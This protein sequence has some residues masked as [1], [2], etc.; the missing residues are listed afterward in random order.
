MNIIVLGNGFNLAHG[1]PTHYTDF[2]KYCKNFDNDDD[3]ISDDQIIADLHSKSVL[4][5][6][7]H[8]IK[9][10]IV[11]FPA[12]EAAFMGRVIHADSLYIGA[13]VI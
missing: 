11:Y 6:I 7:L 9:D 5:F 1:L 10:D 4:Q 13:G 3:P 2:L 8:K 12:P